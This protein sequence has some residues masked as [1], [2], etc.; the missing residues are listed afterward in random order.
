MR[1][2]EDDARIS[3]ALAQLSRDALVAASRPAIPYCPQVPTEPQ[4]AFLNLNCREAFYGGAAGPGKSSALIMAALQYVE[5]PG[6]AALL[7]RKNYQDLDLPD[8]IMDR[9]RGWLT[10][11]SARSVDGGRAWVFPS[12]ATLTFGYL[13]KPNDRYRYQS[14]MFQFIG[15][16]EVSQFTEVEYR[17]LFS[18]LRR[19]KGSPVPP[20]MRSASNPDGVGFGWVKER[21]VNPGSPDRPFIRA[22]LED[23]PYLDYE[24]YVASLDELDPVT[25][26]RLLRGDWEIRGGG[27][28][29]RTEWFPIDPTGPGAARGRAVRYWDLAASEP[30]PGTDPD[31]TVGVKMREYSGDYW[32]E[33]VQRL[34]TRPNLVEERVAETAGRDGRG[35]TVWIE[36]EP[37]ASGKSLL[38]HYRRNVL[39]D[40]AVRGLRQTGAKE[41][42]IKVLSSRAEAGVIRL[43]RGPWTAAFLDEAVAYPDVAHDD[44]LDAASGAYGCLAR[45]PGT[46]QDSVGDLEASRSEK[47][48][49]SRQRL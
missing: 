8:A 11:S 4:A 6:Y 16:D 34:R 17:Y 28:Y 14:A 47:L 40:Y 42:R 5:H 44:Q 41:T 22:R 46:G 3:T 43:V 9:T 19:L 18:R 1:I 38:S 29:F 31:W 37:G 24:A 30:K 36:E 27:G 12:G 21:F 45:T 20:R 33:D 49:Y 35:T 2:P 7:L 26:A 13:Q 15:W 25:R 39:P 48:S 32:I 23:N 10:G